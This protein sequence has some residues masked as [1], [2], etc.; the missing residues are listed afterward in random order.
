MNM[1]HGLNYVGSQ[2]IDAWL[3]EMLTTDSLRLNIYNETGVI[4]E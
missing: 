1:S 2:K 3:I 4:I